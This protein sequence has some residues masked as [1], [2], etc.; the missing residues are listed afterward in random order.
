MAPAGEMQSVMETGMPAIMR[1]PRMDCSGV[2]REPDSGG[3]RFVYSGAGGIPGVDIAFSTL[4]PVPGKTLASCRW[5]M[6]GLRDWAAASRISACAGQMCQRYGT[7]LCIAA[8][9]IPCHIGIGRAGQGKGHNEGQQCR[10]NGIHI[11]MDSILAAA[12]TGHRQSPFPN[13]LDDGNRRGSPLL[14]MQVVQPEPTVW[15]FSASRQDSRPLAFG[16]SG[17]H[18]AV[19]A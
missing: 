13:D 1:T 17:H 11:G 18:P 15:K 8:Q 14:R 4:D 16:Y 9:G 10:G 6:S 5:H 19:G 12:Y 3:K 7:A 2:V